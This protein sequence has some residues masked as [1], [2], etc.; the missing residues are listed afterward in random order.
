MPLRCNGRVIWRIV[1]LL[2]E[3]HLIRL[4]PESARDYFQEQFNFTSFLL[5]IGFLKN[6]KVICII[7]FQNRAPSWYYQLLHFQISI[8]DPE[9]YTCTKAFHVCVIIA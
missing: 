1:G 5:I 8:I 4:T 9:K 7:H 2:A 6:C 3:K